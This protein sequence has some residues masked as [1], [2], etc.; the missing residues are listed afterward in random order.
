MLHFGSRITQRP[1]G[2]AVSNFNAA[3]SA[4]VAHDVTEGPLG[5][6]QISEAAGAIGL[7]DGEVFDAPGSGGGLFT[8]TESSGFILVAFD[9]DGLGDAFL[10]GDS[11]ATS[12]SVRITDGVSTRTV[13]LTVTV[14]RANTAPVAAGALPDLTLERDVTIAATD[15]SS[16]FSDSGDTMSFAADGLPTGLSLS[17]AGILTGTPIAQ[18]SG[19]IV[20]I[21]ATDSIGQTAQS[22]FQITVQATQTATTDPNVT[23]ISV[24]GWRASYTAPIAFD[25]VSDP[26]HVIVGRPGF[27]DF[28]APTTVSDALLL[29]TRIRDTYPNQSSL[30]A[31]D[32]AL[33]EFIYAGD[34]VQGVVNNS[35][36]AYPKP[37]AMW[38]NHDREWATGSTHTVRLAVA[39]AHARAGRP[40]T[41][42]RFTATDES[43]NSTTELV[44]D[45][46]VISYAATGL[47]VP[48]FEA[49][50]D[51]TTLN[52]GELVTVD[53][54]IFPWIGDPFTI[55]TD[56][57]P[58]P[59]SN[60]TVLTFLNDRTGGFGTVYAYVE[61]GAGAGAAVNADPVV[62]ATT[63][64]ATV[65]A[66]A[67]AIQSHNAA[68]FGRSN[69]SGGVIRLTAGTHQHTSF[70]SV[71]VGDIPLIVEAADPAAAATTIYQDR[72]SSVSNGI[73]D[74]LVLR[75]LT[76]RR[77]S[78][79]NVVF[80][81]SAATSGSGSEN[82][83]VTQGCIWDDN[84]LGPSWGAWLYRVGRFWNIDCAGDDCGQ[85]SVFSSVFKTMV[86]IGSGNGSIQS[87]TYHA[88]GCKDLAGTFE[89]NVAAA[90]RPDSVGEFL[91]WCHIGQ[92][93]NAERCV[94]FEDQVIGER[95]AAIV[96]CVLEQYG[97]VTGPCLYISAD[98]DFS[99]IDNVVLH[100]NTVVG[101]RSNLS[102]QDSGSVRIDK[103]L[104]QKFCVHE[105]RNTKSDVFGTNGA[106]IGNWSVIHQ[107]GCCGNS[108]LIG[109]A[110]GDTVGVGS[111]LGEIEAFGDRHGTPAVPLNPDWADDRSFSGTALGD[112]LYAPGPSTELPVIPIGRAPYSHD[113][114]GRPIASDGTA[115]IGAL[116]R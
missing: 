69:A 63:P 76:L 20:T 6:V 55:S 30:T 42:V 82:M 98:G 106:L 33:N 66:A 100:C 108:A 71:A 101:A 21:T 32:V 56:A 103:V 25:P 65:P 57:D 64:F 74:K 110:G 50:L 83:L 8:V 109:S 2:V 41:L 10:Q 93:T 1:R 51:L 94:N 85:G 9:R 35:T 115:V 23:E 39:H 54:T 89:I 77:N 114:L 37:Q 102:Y 96:G 49:N 88:A 87:A 47:S 38:L 105:Q 3:F 43:G 24:E 58:Y 52:Q 99:A 13:P 31:N 84:G 75:N 46:S 11:R 17:G 104:A 18:V 36:R 112:G 78:T 53:A 27:D 81:D 28:G 116:Q 61:A 29:M 91:G 68:T 16:D 48:H 86:A 14:R 80:L 59:S 7:P 73:T 92:G 34:T 111:W 72:G 107:V 97:G 70:S 4:Q 44:S 22:A 26:R 12:F 19:Q 95:G 60:L 67:A 90:H 5:F 79:S 62:A 40:V 15:L 45:T 113:Q